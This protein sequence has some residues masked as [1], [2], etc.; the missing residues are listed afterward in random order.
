MKLQPWTQQTLNAICV[1]Q[2][3]RNALRVN[4]EY[5][6]VPT[7][8]MYKDSTQVNIV[9]GVFASLPF[10]HSLTFA[11]L[12]YEEEKLHKRYSTIT[13]ASPR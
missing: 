7:E 13:E 5:S 8:K 6:K 11:V 4:L 10:F 12:Y 3:D 2:I 1:T 9:V